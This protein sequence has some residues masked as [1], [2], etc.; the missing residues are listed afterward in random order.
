M[1]N[2]LKCTPKLFS[3]LY[4]F[5]PL[6]CIS[7]SNV[8]HHF[9]FQ[10]SFYLSINIYIKLNKSWDYTWQILTKEMYSYIQHPDQETESIQCLRSFHVP[11]SP[12]TT[13]SQQPCWQYQR[14]DLPG[15][16]SVSWNHAM[17]ITPLCW[18][19]SSIR[20]QLHPTSV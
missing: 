17:C 11:P 20:D 8:S 6:L 5:W 13:Q 10:K 14:L 18:Q 4:N 12:Y 9:F 2:I 19:R 15:L 3:L 1:K 16:S 7:L